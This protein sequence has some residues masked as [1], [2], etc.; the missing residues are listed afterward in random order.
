ML[1]ADKLKLPAAFLL[2]N[3]VQT[4]NAV[5]GNRQQ[6][7]REID[8]VTIPARLR[9]AGYRNRKRKWGELC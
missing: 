4:R 9:F 6:K 1:L 7:I 8:A 5:M 3:P 2:R